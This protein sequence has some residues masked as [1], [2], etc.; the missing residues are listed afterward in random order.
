LI[1]D[2]A[3]RNNTRMLNP[4]SL[5]FGPPN[6]PVGTSSGPHP[7]TLTNPGNATLTITSISITS[8]SSDYSQSPPHNCPLSPA[9]LA[10]NSSC[11]I[12]VT[13]RPTVT[14]TRNG[15]ITITDSAVDSPQTVALT[16]TGS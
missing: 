12:K 2:I 4:A 15:T 5:T 1:D 11:T 3:L 14:G 7:I 9:S 10:P 16:G 13:F 8:G 6:Q